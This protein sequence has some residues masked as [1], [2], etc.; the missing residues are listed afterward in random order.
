MSKF[1][2]ADYEMLKKLWPEDYNHLLLCK[3]TRENK[4]LKEHSSKLQK[5]IEECKKEPGD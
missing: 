4:E 2:D 3:L 1:A 5:E